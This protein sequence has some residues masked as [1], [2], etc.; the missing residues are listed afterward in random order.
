MHK[1]KIYIEKLKFINFLLFFKVHECVL[2]SQKSSFEK[3]SPLDTF[4]IYFIY[5]Q[6]VHEFK[7]CIESREKKILL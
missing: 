5:S 7:V 3:K 2:K 1:L 6:L 4:N